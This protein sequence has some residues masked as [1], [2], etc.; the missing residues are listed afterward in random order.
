MK[1]NR[2]LIYKSILHNELISMSTPRIY[3]RGLTIPLSNVVRKTGP[4]LAQE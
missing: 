2:D 1:Q 3:K 4:P